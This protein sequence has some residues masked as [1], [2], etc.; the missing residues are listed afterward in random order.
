MAGI[1]EVTQLQLRLHAQCDSKYPDGP[2]M[3]LEPG[4]SA[5]VSGDGLKGDS[6]ILWIRREAGGDLVSLSRGVPAAQPRRPGMGSRFRK[7]GNDDDSICAT[8]RI[9]A[10]S[11]SHYAEISPGHAAA[12]PQYR[13]PGGSSETRSFNCRPVFRADLFTFVSRRI[14]SIR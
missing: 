2:P 4:C 10:V 6:D 11:H 1:S 8:S 13:T 3:E 12:R 5:A 7:V 9:G 14:S